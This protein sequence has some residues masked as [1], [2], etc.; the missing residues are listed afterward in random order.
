[1]TFNLSKWALE[2]RSFIVYCML[3]ATVAGLLSFVRLGRNEDPSF[4]IKTMVV[5]AAWPGA[6]LADTLDQVTERLERKLQETPSLDFLRSY[7]SAGI[8]TIFVNLKG[9]TPAREVPDIWYHVRKSIGDIRH[10]LPAGVVGPG[11][12]D[13]FGDT[14]GI[15]YGLTA[16]GF[17]HRELRDHAEAIRSRMLRIPDVSKVEILGAQDDRIFVE[18]SVEQLAGLGIDRAALIAALQAQNAV[19]PSGTVQTGNEKLTL[20]ISGAFESE[21]D[22]L[23]VNFVSG[24][25]LIR[26]RDIAE[27]HRG[28]ADP[29]QPLFRVNGQDGIGVAIAMREGG[30]ILT[31]GR[32]VRK[33]MQEITADLPVGIEPFLVADQPVVVD[34]AISDFTTSL[35]QA[36]AIIMGVSFLS[37]GFRAGAVVALSIPLTLA[38]VFPTMEAAGIDLQRISLGALIIALGL[39]VDDAMTTVDV[40]TSRLAQGDS[41]ETAATFAY[42]S[43][44]FPMLTGSF[45]SAAGF[46]PIGF[47]RSS[48]GEYTFSI[49]AVVGITLIL[50]WIV[51]VL[52]TPLLGVAI[53]RKPDRVADQPGR[54]LRGFRA[55]LV[56]AMRLRWLTLGITLVCFVG[57]LL[58]VPLV[59]RQ[60]FPPSDRPDLMVDLRLP[61]NASI[62]ASEATAAR[63]DAVLKADPDV[64][65]WSTYVGRGAIRFYL[66]LD[67]QL[68]N[69]F[70]AQAVIVA[71]DIAARKRLEAK[72]ETVLAEQFPGVVARVSPLGLGPPV[73]WPVQYR[74]SGPDA[75]EVR[76]IALRVAAVMTPHAGVRR[77]NFDWMEPGRKLRIRID[78]DQARLLG[79]SSQAIAS[80]LNSVVSG[81]PVT[82]V[83]DGIYL[84]DV[85]A[86]ATDE[87]RVS[88]ATLRSLQVALPNGRTVPL[89]QLASFEFEQEYPLVWRRDRV[90]T[91]TVQADVAPGEL[92][93]AVVD[94]LAPAIGTL[95]AELPAGYRVVVGG[96]VEESQRSQASVVAVIPLMLFL[97]I[98]FLMI[99][100]QS[101]NLLFLVLS[102]VPLGLIGIVAALLIFG[103]PLGFV[104]ILGI[105][106]L[107]GLIARNAVILIEQI[108]TE[109]AEGRGP[110]DAVIAASLSRFRP[111]TL[112]AI[113]TVLGLI[114]IAATIFWGPMAIAVMGGLLVATVLTLVFL[115][116]LYVTWFRVR[117]PAARTETMAEAHGD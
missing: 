96:T 100:L 49:F 28:T 57:A 29:P 15:I 9:A 34:H 117:E 22:I 13:E 30:D 4:V 42:Q 24:G 39:L 90:P 58:A 106:S 102:V 116:V 97:M 66:P 3:A 55:F 86:R 51:A 35:W 72:L 63:L 70:F 108:E 62:Y 71:K 80:V 33:A 88:L 12:N 19:A 41:K 31:L 5:Q 107:L 95:N 23:A 61:Q 77:V 112:T 75:S 109:K 46:V 59:P 54:V 36:I 20:R 68:P 83:R 1:M 67:V 52:F 37:L 91:L 98:T 65:H 115:P 43:L 11:F 10:T 8:T 2:H 16:D 26:L 60:F 32:N 40:M 93:E 53:L 81:A 101:F 87:Q 7:T 79:L 94:A 84:V 73:G 82:Q 47:A 89:S 56:G 78:Q 92:P 50:S 76:E 114:P 103:K 113:S 110:W 85:L 64:D 104:A 69:D 45:V 111:I 99:Q 18:F 44:A 48:A 21:Q 74:V 25:R 17:T 105:L 14:F 38:I 6:T 27:V